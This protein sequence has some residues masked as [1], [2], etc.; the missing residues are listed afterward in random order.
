MLR[1][2]EFCNV[3]SYKPKNPECRGFG[4]SD[5]IYIYFGCLQKKNPSFFLLYRVIKF[6][7]LFQTSKAAISMSSIYD[8]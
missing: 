1:F 8:K 4:L 5:F 2:L 3:V 6:E 7:E